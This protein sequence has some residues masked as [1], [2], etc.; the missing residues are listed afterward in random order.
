MYFIWYL[1]ISIIMMYF[2]S[3][4]FQLSSIRDPEVFQV[5]IYSIIYNAMRVDYTNSNGT[6]RDTVELPKV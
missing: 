6:R 5:L 3:I 1:Y 2:R 4:F